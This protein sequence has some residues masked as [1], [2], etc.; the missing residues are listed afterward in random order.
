MYILQLYQFSSTSLKNK[1]L[2]Q[3]QT[4]FKE[5]LF[6]PVFSN[7]HTNASSWKNFKETQKLKKKTS[8]YML[9]SFIV[10]IHHSV[11]RFVNM[12]T[13]HAYYTSYCLRTNLTWVTN[14]EQIEKA[15]VYVLALNFYEIIL[16]KENGHLF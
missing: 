12:L 8:I 6:G 11:K 5:Q 13:I 2:Y 15:F 10:S 4:N 9:A 16:F 1:P 14:V 7:E 3:S